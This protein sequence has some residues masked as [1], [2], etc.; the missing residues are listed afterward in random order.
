MLILKN[1]MTRDV[2]VVRESM[3]VFKVM[4]ILND[5]KISGVPVIDND[6]KLI[7]IFTEF[8]SL[9]LLEEGY[10]NKNEPV[11]KYMS[12]NVVSFSPESTIVEVA[13]F[14][15]KSYKNR[16]PVIDEEG[17]VIGIVSRRDILRAILAIQG[18]KDIVD[19]KEVQ[20]ENFWRV[21]IVEDSI[22]NQKLL[23]ALLKNYAVSSLAS[24]GEEGIN[25]YLNSMNEGLPYQVI[26]LDISM[27]EIDGIEVLERIRTIEKD[28][29]LP[30][31]KKSIIIMITVFEDKAKE[32]F[33]KG[34]DDM[35][36][37]PVTELDLVKTIKKHMEEKK[38]KKS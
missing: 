29:G 17:K 10:V 30:E 27:P 21:L 28:A 33:E 9:V 1:I 22:T 4:Q 7:G 23:K 5:Y 18:I 31:E 34:C 35:I 37:K 2:I 13:D 26:L 20:A 15:K 14:F 19:K 38:K 24:N 16:V 12:K 6:K 25:K 11:S 8:D 36:I 3:P 32:A